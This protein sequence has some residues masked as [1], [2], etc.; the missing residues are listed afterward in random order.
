M[1]DA[2]LVWRSR[3]PVSDF[4][5]HRK[6]LF[7]MGDIFAPAADMLEAEDVITKL[8]E[9]SWI[10]NVDVDEIEIVY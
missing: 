10:L 8:C 4:R 7:N 2:A 1:E 9:A 6:L 5:K 3:K